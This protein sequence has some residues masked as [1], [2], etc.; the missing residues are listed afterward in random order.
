MNPLL[1]LF[2]LISVFAV[3]VLCGFRSCD[4]GTTNSGNLQSFRWL[5]LFRSF[6]LFLCFFKIGQ[7]HEGM[8]PI[9]A[10]TPPS[11]SRHAS[12]QWEEVEDHAH[13]SMAEKIS[14]PGENPT[15]K[16]RRFH[17]QRFVQKEWASVMFWVLSA[18]SLAVGV[19]Y[20][21]S[22][23]LFS[24]FL[25][26]AIKTNSAP[27]FFVSNGLVLLSI[28]NWSGSCPN[29]ICRICEYQMGRLHRRGMVSALVVHSIGAA[30]LATLLKR[31]LPQ[32]SLIRLLSLEGKESSF[33]GKLCHC[34]RWFLTETAVS[35]LF[36][37]VYFVAPTL[38]RLNRFPVW[39]LLVLL[40]P[41]YVATVDG[42]GRGSILN[43]A[44]TCAV[45][46]MARRGWW[47]IAAQSLGG[48]LGGRI[49]SLY[50]PDDP[51]V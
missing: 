14:W 34:V 51:K 39:I 26:T 32:E 6:E 11:A 40:Y 20:I 41:L 33:N 27:G 43:P 4:F 1:R 38:L 12:A 37:V 8:S 50:F 47:R 10:W 13:R 42:N 29:L 30:A 48:I 35:C 25:P 18:V 31:G 5:L 46:L 45:C 23:D 15:R 9:A 7:S 44:L 17:F 16:P 3:A 49:M 28:Q 22:S 24:P 2:A 19:D 36:S 21:V